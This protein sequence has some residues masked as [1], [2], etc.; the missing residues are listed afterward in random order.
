MN[1]RSFKLMLENNKWLKKI[2]NLLTICNSLCGF[3]AILYT[4]HVYDD[5][6]MGT[7]ALAVSAW[8]I[9]F[10]MVFDALDGFAAR[11]FNAASMKGLQMDSLADMVTFGVA[12]A[13]IVAVMAHRM[14][15]GDNLFT[16]KDYILIWGV[17]G[18]YLG[19]AALRL[20][21]YNVKAMSPPK[22]YDGNYFSGLP[23]P[24]GAAAIC[25][26]IIF[27]HS[28][29]VIKHITYGLPL[30]AATL[31]LLMI[32]NIQYV[33]VGRWLFSVK[34]NK[35]RL[36]ILCALLAWTAA[37][38]LYAIILIV[39]FYI[40]SGPVMAV[41]RSIGLISSHGVSAAATSTE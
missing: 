5:N 17:S 23:S 29:G 36:F 15:E 3:A 34:R 14:K 2:P 40:F 38:P 39:N 16:P 25:S 28:Y 6:K 12:P 30:Y 8:I 26:A 35:K 13:V 41:L 22:N 7:A 18:V 1:K 32:S 9:M 20:A 19:C 27:F 11:I 37:A 10:A 24:G 31:G 4:L 21:T 33:H